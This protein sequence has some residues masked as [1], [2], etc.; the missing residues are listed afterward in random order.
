ML[1]KNLG[2]LY[3]S[4]LSSFILA[5]FLSFL[6]IFF[7]KHISTV[8]NYLRDELFKIRGESPKFKI[9]NTNNDLIVIIDIDEKSLNELGQW[10]WSRNIIS[11][12]LNNA[13]KAGIGLT[14]LDIVFAEEDKSSPHKIIKRLNIKNFEGKIENYDNTLANTIANTPTIVGYVFETNKNIKNITPN[15]NMTPNSIGRVYIKNPNNYD[16]NHIIEASGFTLNIPIIQNNAN[17]SG[18]FNNTPDK[19]GI[20]RNVPLIVKYNTPNFG[21]EY[22]PSLALQSIM[23]VYNSNNVSINLYERG[24][25]SIQ[26]GDLLIPTDNHGRLFVNYRGPAKTFKYISAVDIYN[27]NLKNEDLKGKIGLLGTSAIGLM[28]LRA[29]PFD[30][31]FPGVEVHA[32][33]IDNILS[34]DILHKPAWTAGINVTIIIFLSFF[35]ILTLIFIPIYLNPVFVIASI[36]LVSYG[37][38]YVHFKEFF[39]ILNIVFPLLTIVLSTIVATLINYFLEIKKEEAIKKKFASKVSKV[40]MDDLLK[41]VHNDNFQVQEK[42]VTV[43]FSDI[44]GFTNISEEMKSAK[45]LITYLNKYMEPMSQI[46][47]E[48]NGTIDKYI[49]DSI[50]AYWN[51]PLKVNNHADKALSAALTQIK[52]LESLNE[53]LKKEK[54][55]YID[56]GI[57]LNTGKVIVGEMGSIGRSDYTVIGDSVNLGARLESLCKYYDSKINISNFTKDALKEEYVFR[58]LD[59]VNVKGKTKPVDIWQV[60]DFG[61]PNK[62]LKEELDLYH[63]GIS[64]YKASNF[65]DAIEIFKTLNNNPNK[66]SKK[67]YKIYIERCANYLKSPKQNFNGIYEHTSKA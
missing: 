18:F 7:E 37:L 6:Y 40:V 32:N 27:N 25:E 5:F 8:D 42:E 34:E 16:E 19:S 4:I 13:T 3:I 46:I 54:K 55:P 67:I 64:L 65:K 57:G 35:I 51:A 41:N 10:P 17:A 39:I 28:D 21:T 30:S 58:Y 1:F 36:L 2:K 12:I 20:I 9:P 61:E 59:K 22:F 38:Y 31:V 56:I 29:T 24:I 53:L 11:Q 66:T 60:L 44:R 62:A 23:A 26:V 49:G 33:V 45:E 52:A 63:E 15:S 48:H 47:I 50:M 43:F 14:A